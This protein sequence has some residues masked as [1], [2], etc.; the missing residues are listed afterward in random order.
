[1][2]RPFLDDVERYYTG[3]FSAHGA[4][5]RGVD[6]NG[7]ESQELRFAQ[8]ARVVDRD[9][10][11]SLNDYG[12]GY[13]ALCRW[14]AE[15]GYEGV[16][17]RGFDLS[18]PMLEHAR[19]ELGPDV[20]LVDREDALAPA[21][22]TVASGIFNVKL[23]AGDA[24]WIEYSFDTIRRMAALSTRGLAFNMLTS[25]SDADRMEERLHYGDPRVYFDF[26][27]RELS[28]Q[29][30]LLHDYGLYEFTIVVR[31]E[32]TRER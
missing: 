17:Y 2:S 29:V 32:P 1:V 12:C 28:R 8:L 24:E 4:T 14:L 9:G 5:A 18:A 22:Y 11:F 3:R 27:K 25:Y 26:C 15:H 20:T 13:G 19:G 16:D 10:A 30:A 7:P 6:W 23:D 21:D 31:L